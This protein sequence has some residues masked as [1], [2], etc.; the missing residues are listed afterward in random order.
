MKGLIQFAALLC[1]ILCASAQDYRQSMLNDLNSEKVLR[2]YNWED[3]I[4]QHPLPN[5]GIVSMDGMSVLKIENTNHAPLH[6]SLLKIT[7]SV[8]RKID[9]FS[10]DMKCVNV[11][12]VNAYAFQW[13]P[14]QDIF[15]DASQQAARYAAN[16]PLNYNDAAFG[17]ISSTP[18]NVSGG[19]E[20]T[21]R[22]WI[23]F[24]G[25]SNWKRY[26]FLRIAKMN[27]NPPDSVE[28]IVQLPGPGTIYLRPIKIRG[29]TQDWWGAAL[30]GV[31]AGIGGTLFGCCGALIGC[32]AAMGKARRFVLATTK[33][34]IALGIIL[35]IAGVAAVVSRQPYFIYYPLVL[36]GGVLTF[37]FS[38]NLYPIKRRYE[39]QE[40]RRMASMD[41][42]GR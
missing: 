33:C 21:N 5:G 17:L 10:I 6:I 23:D 37:V 4:S 16:G 29:V 25:T 22:L 14:D 36:V 41:A 12:A 19:D 27:E 13:D 8:V 3:L 30:A 39:D 7:G 31:A 20:I 26:S 18:P 42:T 28:L 2:V 40:I 11:S 35:T 34:L 1:S 32:L 38:I 15:F 24:G 9:S